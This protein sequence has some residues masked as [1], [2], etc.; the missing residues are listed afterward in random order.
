MQ[1]VAYPVLTS[2]VFFPLLAAFGLFFFRGDSAVRIYTLIVSVIELML[3]FPLFTNFKLGSA[4]FQFVERIQWVKQWDIEYY[5]GTDGISFLMVILTI[6]VLPLCVLCSWSYIQTRVKEFHFCLLFMTAAC[7]GVFTSL[8][9]VLFYVFWE[10]MLIPMYL[11]IAVWGGPEKKYASLK[12]FLYTLAGSALL[13]VAIVAFRVV[14][15]TFAIPE[16]M[17]KTFS[18]GFQFWAFLA[19]ALAFAIKVP[20]FPF[21]TWLPAA[22]VQAPTAGSVI[23]ASVLLKMGTYGFLRFNLPL[24]PAASEYFAP[25][26]IAFS[27]AS[28]IYGGAVALGQND[29]KKV[30][31][32]SSVS[33]MGF[34][35]LG[36]FLFNL[37]GLEGALFQMLN[38]G[39]V[40]GG[41]FMMIGAIYE[42]SHSRDIY[43]NLGLG[44]YM[45]A[46]MGFWGLFALSSFGF[47]GTNS[48]VGEML[49]FIGA[50]EKSPWI[51]AMIVPGAMI[52][53]AYML[54][55]SLKLAWGR[56]STWKGWKDLNLREWT[57]LA[58][59]A[60]FVF[61]IGLAPG[62]TFRVMD[63]SL[64]KLQNDVHTKAQAVNIEDE[65]PLEMAWNSIKNIVK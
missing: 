2:L 50:F 38:H 19:L 20:M 1:E 56:P 41:L 33:H 28:I 4:E 3:S 53:A 12:F 30:I 47:P 54:R 42:R 5:L 18:F 34:V 11:L 15:G 9:L 60:V 26:M 8:D 22:H 17:E 6:A 44:K 43:D 14:G 39:I 48:F 37:R 65:R 55:I 32:Y 51:G 23:L 57:Y 63:A 40:T 35:T 16:L 45:P 49:V 25:M 13:L 7:V 21:H 64:I 52:A 31:A 61:Y 36:I 10:A 29:I 24:T 46:Y 62:L 27:I 59:P 58:I